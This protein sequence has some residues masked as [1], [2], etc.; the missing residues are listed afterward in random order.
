MPKL[1][2]FGEFSNLEVC[3]QTVLPDRST[4]KRPKLVESAKIEKGQIRH[5]EIIFKHCGVVQANGF[6]V[7]FLQISSKSLNPLSGGG[8]GSSTS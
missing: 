3:G 5:F 4:L 8:G 7:L 6:Q 2:N 1:T